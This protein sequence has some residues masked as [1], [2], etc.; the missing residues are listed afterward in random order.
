[1]LIEQGVDMDEGNNNGETPLYLA[2]HNGHLAVM[3]YLLEQGASLDKCNDSGKTPL[4]AAA[5]SGREEI[6]RN[7]LEQGADMEKADNAGYTPLHKA[8]QWGHIRIAKLLMCHGANLNAATNLLGLLPINLARN[9]KMSQA[10]RDEQ[11]RRAEAE[12][13]QAGEQHSNKRPHLELAG[14]HPCVPIPPVLV[15]N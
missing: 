14:D 2:C 10:I 9:E 7:L 4:F 5:I 8:S 15:T 1:M 11:K 6:A 3:Q 12:E 13:E